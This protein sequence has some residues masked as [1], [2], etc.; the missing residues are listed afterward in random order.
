MPAWTSPA[1]SDARPEAAGCGRLP[2]PT[3]TGL[4]LWLLCASPALA[5][6]GRLATGR[7]GA[8]PLH[9]LVHHTGWW[10][11]A[12]LLATLAVTP[13][14]RLSAWLSARVAPRLGNRWGR[15]LS[16]WNGL[17]RQRRQLGLWTFGYASAHLG[18][19]AVLDAGSATEL[20][21][22][23]CEQ[24]HLAWG[25]AAWLLLLPLAAT[26]NGAAMRRLGRHWA[27]LH[28]L[29]YPAA[30]LG[31]LHTW[32]QAK[33]GLDLPWGFALATAAL[34][35]SRLWAWRVGDRAAAAELDPARRGGLVT[36]GTGAL[37]RPPTAP[38]RWS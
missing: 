33:A 17:V 4:V 27:T 23:L 28:L 24:R 8:D 13:L 32:L 11:L 2:R 30:G 10:A 35:A 36:P 22:S 12:L 5:L 26:S 3:R 7:L 31:L 14:R 16:D 9:T 34:L 19:Y 1:T 37:P 38:R 21:L 18:L 20:W 29:A 15:R 25:A 6:A